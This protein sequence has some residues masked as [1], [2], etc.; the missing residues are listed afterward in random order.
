MDSSTNFYLCIVLYNES[1]K[2]SQAVQSLVRHISHLNNIQV[3]VYLNGQ[4]KQDF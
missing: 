4:C 2:S 1:L 3:N